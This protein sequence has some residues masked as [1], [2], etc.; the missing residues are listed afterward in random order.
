M[1]SCTALG[2]V[3]VADTALFGGSVTVA[4]ATARYG[5]LVTEKNILDRLDFTGFYFIYLGCLFTSKSI[6][7]ELEAYESLLIEPERLTLYN[8]ANLL[9]DDDQERADALYSRSLHLNAWGAE[10][11]HNYGSNLTNLHSQEIAI[12][13]LK[14]SLFLEPNVADVWCNLGLAY[15]GLDRFEEAERCFRFSLSMDTSHAQS[16]INLGNTLINVFRPEEAIVLLE[17][18]L[19]LDPSSHNS[20]WNLALAYL[21]LGRF[22]KG[23]KY[24]EA[25]FKACKEFEDLSPPTSGM[26]VV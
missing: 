7:L 25:R 4:G 21:L 9:K 19:E 23:W 2:T 16:H 13:A 12:K 14:I 10:C 24:Y 15:Y 26:Q 22:D 20:L 17:R 11:W 5:F 3:G 8:L 18:G 6:S 1:T